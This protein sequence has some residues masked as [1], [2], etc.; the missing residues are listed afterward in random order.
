[1]KRSRLVTTARRERRGAGVIAPGSGGS[2]KARKSVFAPFAAGLLGE[3][4]ETPGGLKRV[5]SHTARRPS[6][7]RARGTAT[8]TCC[9]R[10]SGTASLQPRPPCARRGGA[11]SDTCRGLR[12]VR[13]LLMRFRPG[14]RG[15]RFTD[16]ALKDIRPDRGGF[17]ATLPRD[18]RPPRR[19]RLARHA[20]A[21]R[22]HCGRTVRAL[23]ARCA[24][25]ASALR[26][27]CGRPAE[28]PCEH[29]AG[30][31]RALCAPCAHTVRALCANTACVHCVRTLRAHCACTV[32]ALCGHW[33][34]TLV[35][36]TGCVRW[37]R[38]L[39]V[40]CS[41]TVRALRVHCAYTVCVHCACT[42]PAPCA[43]RAYP[44]S[45]R[46]RTPALSHSSTGGA[47]AQLQVQRAGASALG[48][49]G[50]EQCDRHCDCTHH[51]ELVKSSCQMRCA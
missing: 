37:L 36:H 33:L 18:L 31:A 25:T 2:A 8:S 44:Y 10:C 11:E 21:L 12:L 22:V 43:N 24:R 15:A 38:A 5:T 46:A 14:G 51:N 29:C 17:L 30:T 26:A 45:H 41:C 20:R 32:G 1:M 3:V 34:R 19:L 13:K 40:H 7:R 47:V 4:V 35:A 28:A 9:G 6:R 23:W 39:C 49:A 27:P 50:R 16:G 48:A 42:V